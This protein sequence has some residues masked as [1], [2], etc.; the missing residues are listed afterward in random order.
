ME[1]PTQLCIFLKKKKKKQEK[2]GEGD[3]KKALTASA[4][5]QVNLNS[6]SVLLNHHTRIEIL[7]VQRV[8]ANSSSKHISNNKT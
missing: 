4:F 8:P 3:A 6:F 7:Q 5:L 1:V 2:G